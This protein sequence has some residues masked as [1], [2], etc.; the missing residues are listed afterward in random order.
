MSDES[1]AKNQAIAQA[2]SIAAMVAALNVDYDRLEELQEELAEIKK[3]FDSEPANEGVDFA[4]VAR[5]H[6]N[7]SSGQYDELR[8]LEAAAGDCKDEEEARERIQEDALDVQVR[9]DW[10]TPGEIDTIPV[11]FYIL[12]C[13][14][15]PAVRIRGEL[16]GYQIITAWIEYQDWGIPW[17][18]LFDAPIDQNTLLQYCQQFW[19]GE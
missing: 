6:P 15:G 3:E 12:L 5:N 10:H 18:Q 14:G 2:E 16:D 13:T 4:W 11:E 8:E 7:F 19:F 17:T 9:S 1:N